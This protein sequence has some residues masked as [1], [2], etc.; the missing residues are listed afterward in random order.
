MQ[1]GHVVVCGMLGGDMFGR[2]H[3]GFLFPFRCDVANYVLPR[4]PCS[5]VL[6]VLKTKIMTT[7]VVTS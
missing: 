2:M 5:A 7:C 3:I 6:S 4:G 1:D